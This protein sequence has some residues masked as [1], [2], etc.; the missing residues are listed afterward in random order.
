VPILYYDVNIIPFVLLSIILISLYNVEYGFSQ[1]R[2]ESSSDSEK[3]VKTHPELRSSQS[4]KIHSLLF[5][6]QS[7]STPEV[8]ARNNNLSV[9]DNKIQ[10]YIYLDSADSIVN[11]PQ[12]IDVIDSNENIAVAFVSSEQINQ[13]AQLDFVVKISLPLTAVPRE[14]ERESTE[15]T[16]KLD[17][18]K[19][20]SV[21]LE[22]MS[23]SNPKLFAENN[24]LSVSDNKIQV[25]IYL[26]SADSIV[27]IPQDI[28][29][30]DSNEN[31]AIAFVSSEQ[32]NQLTQLDFVV[33]ISPPI[34]ASIPISQ[35]GDGNDNFALIG[36]GVIIA[37]II[38]V[39][40][41]KKRKGNRN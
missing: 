41:S 3:F 27:N 33:K 25:Y 39:I 15:I 8:F 31:I 14:T 34:R 35:E 29:V 28:D 24:N 19:I 10:V 20:N 11:I 23:S 40:Y 26:D 22:W 30:I 9:S 7:S 32:I 38:G 21:I 6:W 18:P 2:E 17:D 4:L 12:D 16:T 5:E 37:V 13:L 1:T 36:I